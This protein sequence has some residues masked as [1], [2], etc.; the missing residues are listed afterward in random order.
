M[1]SEKF[2]GENFEKGFQIMLELAIF[3]SGAALGVLIVIIFSRKGSS[4]VLRIDTSDPSEDPYI[5]L[6]L[7]ENL[8]SVR[9]KSQIKLDISTESYISQK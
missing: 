5:F 4:G 8:G 1:L 6:E 7:H 9:R 2:P 3:L